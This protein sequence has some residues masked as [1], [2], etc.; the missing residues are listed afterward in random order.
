MKP[1]ISNKRQQLNVVTF[2]VFTVN[3]RSTQQQQHHKQQQQQQKQQQQ[4]Q[5]I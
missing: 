3:V 4:Q 5:Q 2:C 1:T